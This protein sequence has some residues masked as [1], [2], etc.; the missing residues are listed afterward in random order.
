MPSKFY[1]LFCF[2]ECIGTW[3]CLSQHVLLHLSF[4]SLIGKQ[5][6]KLHA[7][8][9]KEDDFWITYKS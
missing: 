4:K 1:K 7:W 8:L 6:S 5:I 9:S 2:H 3:V